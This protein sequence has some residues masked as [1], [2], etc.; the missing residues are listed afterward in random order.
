MLTRRLYHLRFGLK[1]KTKSCVGLIA[2]AALSSTRIKYL[3]RFCLLKSHDYKTA[4]IHLEIASN[5][6]P[7]FGEARIA[8]G[9]GL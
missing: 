1:R 8:P 6:L 2:F 4:V 7:D 9:R 5:R 3:L